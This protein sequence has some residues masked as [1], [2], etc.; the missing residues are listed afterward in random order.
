MRLRRPLTVLMAGAC[1]VAVPASAETLFLTWDFALAGKRETHGS[2][3][4]LAGDR[5]HDDF[6]S[7]R[8][9]ERTREKT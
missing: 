5:E 4:A 2:V 1:C 7:S 3:F 9:G 6:R 8:R